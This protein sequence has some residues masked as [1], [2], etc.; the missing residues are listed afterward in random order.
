[1]LNA[2]DNSGVQ[3]SSIGGS[4]VECSPATRAARVIFFSTLV[5]GSGNFQLSRLAGL[6]YG[7][8]LRFWVVFTIIVS[9][10]LTQVI[11]VIFF[12]TRAARE[13]FI[14]KRHI[15]SSA[16]YVSY[17]HSRMRDSSLVCSTLPSNM[18]ILETPHTSFT[19]ICIYMI[20]D[21]FS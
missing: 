21:T 17:P 16:H 10:T 18:G 3:I 7:L 20:D 12:S 13:Y 11:F 5:P 1:M 4:V 15:H 14:P 2:D 9:L 6:G 8:G 19:I